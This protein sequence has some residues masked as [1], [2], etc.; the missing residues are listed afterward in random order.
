MSMPGYH[1]VAK[2]Y[3]FV[4]FSSFHGSSDD[5]SYLLAF[6]KTFS[7]QKLRCNTKYKQ[8]MHN[9]YINTLETKPYLILL[10]YI[11]NNPITRSTI[12]RISNLQPHPSTTTLTH[13]KI[14]MYIWQTSCN[15]VSIS[16]KV[17]NF[18]RNGKQWL[19]RMTILWLFIFSNS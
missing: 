19:I 16:F 11:K 2:R 6:L 3:N 14:G 13:E 5:F 9:V 15:L 1:V 12:E 17:N 8:G 4:D 7:W 10:K 18:Q